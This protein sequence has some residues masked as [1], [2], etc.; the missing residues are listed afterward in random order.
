MILTAHIGNA[1]VEARDAMPNIVA[2]NV[3]LV[4]EGRVPK[5]VVNKE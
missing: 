3:I 2:D 4:S 5:F 1:T